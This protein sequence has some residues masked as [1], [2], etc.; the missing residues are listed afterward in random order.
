MSPTF[1][2]SPPASPL[3]RGVCRPE[4]PLPFVWRADARSRQIRRPDGISDFFQ[5]KRYSI[6]PF[7]SVVWRNLLSK[8]RCRAA[9]RDEAVE[10][11]PQVPLVHFALSLAGAR[12]RL[13]W[14]ASSPN[15]NIV[16]PPC[17]LEGI[18]PAAD[19]GEEMA[20]LV[21]L[22]LM[23]AHLPYVPLVNVAFWYQVRLD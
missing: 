10:L 9:L 13:A 16:W 20:L 8:D 5:V 15:A 14:A 11:W 6:E 17:E 3:A 22:K 2:R 21:S 19:P 23:A 1:Q 18:W 4:N 12:K 7:K